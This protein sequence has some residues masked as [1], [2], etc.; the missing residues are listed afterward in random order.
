MKIN[1]VIYIA[2]AI[3]FLV[4]L[5]FVFK[6]KMQESP[7]LQIQ[8]LQQ[9]SPA[10]SPSLNTSKTFEIVIQNKKITSGKS[11][12]SV[13]EGD[14]VTLVVTSDEPEEFHLHAYDNSVNL[15]TNT[16]SE[17]KFTADKTGRF[18]FELEESQTELGAIEVLPK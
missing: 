10:P 7:N 1:P 6:P 12:I 11:T 17:L 4:S 9:Q 18:P 2:V 5:F 13:Q 16:P 14:E 3:V 8:N 15:E